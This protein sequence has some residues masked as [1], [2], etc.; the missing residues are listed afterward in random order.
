MYMV[1]YL[2]KYYMHSTTITIHNG[3]IF[4]NYG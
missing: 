2:G 1:H 3:A 4:R